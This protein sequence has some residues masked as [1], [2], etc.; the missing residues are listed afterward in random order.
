LLLLIRNT[1]YNSKQ[2]TL[3]LADRKEDIIERQP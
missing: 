3:K 2:T 1:Y